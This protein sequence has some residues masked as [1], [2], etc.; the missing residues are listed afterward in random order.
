M[1]EIDDRNI[2]DDLI[3][4]VAMIFVLIIHTTLDNLESNGTFVIVRN[5]I[6]F[7]C[8]AMFFMLCGKYGLQFNS[9]KY[10]KREYSYYNFYVKKIY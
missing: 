3:R 10:A 4:T 7:T 9:N 1:Q 8:N 6:C 5:T 2:Q